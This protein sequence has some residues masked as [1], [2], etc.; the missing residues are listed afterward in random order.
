MT[1]LVVRTLEPPGGAATA[2][3]VAI[4]GR[5][6]SADDLV[7][8][9]GAVALP[10]VRWIFPQ[11]WLPFVH[12][13]GTGWA[14]YELPPDDRPGVLESRRRLRRLLERLTAPGGVPSDRVAL[15]GFS[16]GAVVSLDAGLRFPQP[17]AGIAALSGYLF[18]PTS[19]AAELAPAQRRL[20][21]FLAHGIFDGVVPLAGS[22]MAAAALREAGL[23]VELH[24]YP[25]GHEIV[26]EELAD[27]RTFLGRCLKVP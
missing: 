25:M 23:P 27:L 3:V 16:Q 18:D 13:F 6:A 14:W 2:A 17:L 9:A 8:I 4:H 24:E 26:P 22:R 7:P 5:G 12:P 1:E 15:V 21:V 19:L 20:P 10:G 11:G